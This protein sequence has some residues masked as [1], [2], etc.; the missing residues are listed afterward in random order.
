MLLGLGSRP[1]GHLPILDQVDD[2]NV[3]AAFQTIKERANH[4]THSLPSQYDY[5]TAVSYKAAA[6]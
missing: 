1:K 3:Q 4:L 6:A 2:R 5:L